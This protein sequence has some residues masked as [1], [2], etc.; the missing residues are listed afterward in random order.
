MTFSL[1][2]N[3]RNNE[4]VMPVYMPNPLVSSFSQ[5]FP[6]LSFFLH[7]FQ[8]SFIRPPFCPLYPHHS[9]PTSQMI[10]CTASCSSSP[11]TLSSSFSYYISND[12]LYSI[13]LILSVHFILI[14]LLL[15]L[16]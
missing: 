14:I 15:H 10:H 3:D 1:A 2:L 5:N 8:H 12:S 4:V 7:H 9:P 6:N 11:S 13:L 16:K